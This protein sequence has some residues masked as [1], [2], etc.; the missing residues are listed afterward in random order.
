VKGHAGMAMMPFTRVA[1]VVNIIPIGYWFIVSHRL[2]FNGR[3]FLWAA[4]VG[5]LPRE[6]EELYGSWLG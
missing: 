3:R 6:C 2:N 5:D 4:V 1:A